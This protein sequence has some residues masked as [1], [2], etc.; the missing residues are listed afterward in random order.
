M[1]YI[2]NNWVTKSDFVWPK[3]NRDIGIYDGDVLLHIVKNA[4]SYKEA[5]SRFEKETGKRLLDGYSARNYE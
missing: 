5:L 1:K 2:G 4:S 3:A